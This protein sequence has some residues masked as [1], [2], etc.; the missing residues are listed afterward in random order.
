[1]AKKTMPARLIRIIYELRA[2]AIYGEGMAAEGQYYTSRYNGLRTENYAG[3]VFVSETTLYTVRFIEQTPLKEL[4]AFA[5][6][7]EVMNELERITR[8]Y[9]ESRVERKMKSLDALETLLSDGS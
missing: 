4:F 2:I 6:S 5:V 9:M 8:D 1:L 3:S 7:D